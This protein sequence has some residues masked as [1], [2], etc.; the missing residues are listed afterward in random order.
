MILYV[1]K[2]TV[3]NQDDL[4]CTRKQTC[5]QKTVILIYPD[6]IDI[7]CLKLVNTVVLNLLQ[8]CHR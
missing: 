7:E 2:M 4:K 6:L 3:M 5:P 1:C 8:K